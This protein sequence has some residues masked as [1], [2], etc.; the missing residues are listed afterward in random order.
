MTTQSFSPDEFSQDPTTP[1]DLQGLESLIRSAGNY[2]VPS[3]QLRPRLMEIATNR[4]AFTT[5][6]LC[7]VVGAG[8]LGLFCLAGLVVTKVVADRILRAAPP[9]SQEML[10]K[11][12]SR[13]YLEHEPMDWTLTEEYRRAY[14]RRAVSFEGNDH[15]D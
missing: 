1:G 10:E 9:S 11:A 15:D 3:D 8:L 4:Q 2:V 12:A 5:Q 14:E 6:R 13:S 7:L